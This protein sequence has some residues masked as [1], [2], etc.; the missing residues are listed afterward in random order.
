MSLIILKTSY[1]ALNRLTGKSYSNGDP[2]VY[3]SYDQTSYN[4]LTIA[5]GKGRRTGMS[6]ASGQTA[7]SYDAM[8]RVVAERRTIGSMTKT[9]SSSY[10]L[11]GS[12]ASVTYPSGRTVAYT[13]SAVGRPPTAVDQANGI[14]FAGGA[15]YAPHGALASG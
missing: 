3:Y 13:S 15:A 1:D 8:G 2:S 11:D 6:D 4:G 5:Y 7:W 12:L 14:N 10:N 9:L